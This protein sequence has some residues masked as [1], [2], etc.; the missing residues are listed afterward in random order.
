MTYLCMI[1]LA[2]YF[3]DQHNKYIRWRPTPTYVLSHYC[4]I[5]A[6]YLHMSLTHLNPP[7]LPSSSHK[8][9][10]PHLLT[11][12]VHTT[13]IQR[14]AHIITHHTWLTQS[15][16]HITLSD[17][18][19]L[20]ELHPL[21]HPTTLCSSFL[22]HLTQIDSLHSLCLSHTSYSRSLKHKSPYSHSH[23]AFIS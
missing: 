6:P 23:R 5:H 8:G 16:Q 19:Y 3:H 22:P 2:P 10:H 14:Q 7:L 21:V 4:A 20:H 9:K 15:L 13:Y 18:P 17:T 11:K 12:Y 1:S